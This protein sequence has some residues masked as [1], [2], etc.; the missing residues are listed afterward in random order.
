MRGVATTIRIA[1]AATTRIE[2]VDPIKIVA[3]VVLCLVPIL[4]VAALH[5]QNPHARSVARLVTQHKDAGIVTMMMKSI[6]N[7]A[8]LLVLHLPLMALTQIGT[9]IVGLLTI[10]LEI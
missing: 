8:K 1:G 4:I 6:N 10:S 2:D 5:P 3:V 9:S 7:K